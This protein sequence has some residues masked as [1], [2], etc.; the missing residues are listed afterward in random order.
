MRSRE[1]VAQQAIDEFHRRF[2][3]APVTVG[4]S[5]GRVNL[6]GEHTDYN[7]GFVLP[8]A[9]PCFTAVA[10]APRPGGLVR[11][12]SPRFDAVYEA[13]A[14]APG[15]TGGFG[16]FPLG[17]ARV[18]GFEGGFDVAIASDVPMSAGMSS[19]AALLLAS[20]HA[21]QAHEPAG[22]APSGMEN[23]RAARRAENDF[24]GVPCGLMDPFIVACGR[25]GAACLLD[26]LDETWIEVPAALPGARWAVVYSGIPR[27]LS[28]GDYGAKVRE[29]REALARV[30]AATGMGLAAL[31]GLEAGA[32]WREC[33]IAEGVSDSAAML[34]RHFVTENARVDRMRRA[35]G[36][37]DAQAAGGILFE[38]HWSLSRD[39]GVSLPAIDAF[40]QAAER[41]DGVFGVRITGAGF[42]G[43][44]LALLAADDALDGLRAAAAASLPPSHEILEVPG[45]CGG[46]TGWTL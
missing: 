26:C 36:T 14:D 24:V 8:A 11:A 17:M 16:D 43:S 30:A 37:G 23:A 38:G 41:V 40:V 2:G 13:P 42:G 4:V 29:S 9:V 5:P 27:E 7:G 3:A 34:L 22:C 25:P 20:C 44:L 39:F 12:A 1:D 18:L 45:F 46:A 31:R 35:L 6:I 15:A 21:I 19:S 28:G 33:R 32:M 10:F